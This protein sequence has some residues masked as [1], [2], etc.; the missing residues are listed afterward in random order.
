MSDYNYSRYWFA[1]EAEAATQLARLA[2]EYYAKG[3]YLKAYE[4]LDPIKLIDESFYLSFMEDINNLLETAHKN[5]NVI[6]ITLSKPT[7]TDLMKLG[8]PPSL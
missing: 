5:G 8:P 1:R 2:Q 3:Q 4:A 6:S 7:P